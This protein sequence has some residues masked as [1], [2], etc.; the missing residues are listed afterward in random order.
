MFVLSDGCDDNPGADLR[1]K[2]LIDAYNIEDAYVINTFGY[3][4]DHD[5]K[6]MNQISNYKGGTFTFID[7]IEKASEHFILAMSGM[8]SVFA[9][10]V[11]V[12]IKPS[13][14]FNIVKIYGEDFLWKNIGE[15][16]Y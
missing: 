1:C 5:P 11:T 2:Q 6:M 12:Q 16:T 10:K 4:K 14:P 8:L 3:G 9:N 7:K 13:P 15:N